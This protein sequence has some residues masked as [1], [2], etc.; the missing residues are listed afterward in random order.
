MYV[1][2]CF[3]VPYARPHFSADLNQIWQVASSH[4]R[5]DHGNRIGFLIN[6]NLVAVLANTGFYNCIANGFSTPATT[7]CYYGFFQQPAF[8]IIMG[9]KELLNNKAND[10]K[11]SY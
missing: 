4:L 9:S 8:H 7:Q 6:L 1:C 3:F 11:H 10:R 5:D 2:I